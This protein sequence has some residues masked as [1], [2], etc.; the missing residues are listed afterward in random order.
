MEPCQ[1]P[2]TPQ[3]YSLL[4]PLRMRKQEEGQEINYVPPRELTPLL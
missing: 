3:P 2:G 4:A 1:Q